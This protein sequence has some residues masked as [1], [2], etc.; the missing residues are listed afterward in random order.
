MDNTR[1]LWSDQVEEIDLSIDTFETPFG[2]VLKKVLD[3]PYKS[4]FQRDEL[5]EY[6]KSDGFK[7]KE[8][9]IYHP[10]GTLK[11]FVLIAHKK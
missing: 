9:K 10:A 5:V 2:K 3:H 4:M 6:I 1:P 7:I 11:Y 8:Y